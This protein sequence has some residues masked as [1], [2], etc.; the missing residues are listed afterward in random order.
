LGTTRTLKSILGVAL[1]SGGLAVAGLGLAPGTAHADG[2]HDWC[3]GNPKN[4]PYV[5]N[6]MIDWVWNVC[7]TWYATNYGMGNV[8]SQADPFQFGDGDNLPPPP[9]PPPPGLINKDNCQQILG[10]FCPHA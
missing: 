8:T 5:P 10:M 3:P 9:P 1:L 7:H 2:P 6:S 4:M